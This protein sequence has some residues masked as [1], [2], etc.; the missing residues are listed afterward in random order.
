MVDG[1]VPQGW[2]EAAYGSVADAVAGAVAAY[3]PRSAAALR[4]VRSLVVPFAVWVHALPGRHTGQALTAAELAGEGL[5]DRY[6]AG[7]LASAPRSSRATTRTVLRRV[8]RGLAVGGVAERLGYTPVQPPYS[9]AECARWITLCRQQPTD[10]LRRSMS[11]MV[12]L[13]AG[14]GLG[15]EDQRAIAPEHIHEIDM[16]AGGVVLAV[17]VPGPAPRGR[18]VIVRGPYADLLREA[19]DLHAKAR[20]GR[21]TPLCGVKVERRN[22][23]NRVAAKAVTAT[24]TG[25]ELSAARLRNTWLVACM[26]SP[27]PLGALLHAAGLRTPRTLADLLQYCPPADPAQVAALLACVE[28]RSSVVAG[29]ADGERQVAS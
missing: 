2:E 12:A 6:V 5:V 27:V 26:S 18:T 4:N 16:G 7:P 23:A 21:K 15:A 8:V 10:P 3:Q 1:W 14:A 24:G 17:R 20:R 28:S 13:G 22:G 9:A 19:L 11:A 25:V 29:D